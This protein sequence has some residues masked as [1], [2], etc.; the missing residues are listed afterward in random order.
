MTFQ[1]RAGVSLYTSSCEL[2]ETCVFDKQFPEPLHCA[3]PHDIQLSTSFGRDPLSRS[4]GVKLPSSLTTVLSSALGYSPRLPVSVLVRIC[5]VVPAEVF[6]AP[7]PQTSG[8]NCPRGETSRC[9]DLLNRPGQN[10]QRTYLAVR[11]TLKM[12]HSFGA[13]LPCAVQEY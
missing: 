5:T 10:P 4:Y 2:A 13:N 8:S 12:R 3:L 9:A 1:H 6:L 11:S 7:S